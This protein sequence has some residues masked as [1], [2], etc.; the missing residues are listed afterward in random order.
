MDVDGI[1]SK[2][3]NRFLEIGNPQQAAQDVGVPQDSISEFLRVCKDHPDV[4]NILMEDELS[5]PDFNDPD[6]VRKHIL[7]K[8]WREANF[9][10]TGAQQAARISAL[11]TIGEITG[12]E[13][14]KK[15]DVNSNSEG[16]MMMIPVMDASMWEESA[17]KMQEDLKKR[18]R[19]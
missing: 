3:A 12:I 8:L 7:K 6:S 2:Y 19:E 18:A 13:A 10:G 14:A 9:R 15:V 5:M 11:K 16:G 4:Q 1:Y 17:E